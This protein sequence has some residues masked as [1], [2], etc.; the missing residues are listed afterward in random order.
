M[1]STITP[2]A[3]PGSTRIQGSTWNVNAS[4]LFGVS[5][6]VSGVVSGAE[7]EWCRTT[8]TMEY[9]YV[10]V[11][12][13]TSPAA[14]DVYGLT[15]LS[16]VDNVNRTE[17][18]NVATLHTK[19]EKIYLDVGTSGFTQLQILGLNPV[20][21]DLYG[22]TYGVVSGFV[23][24]PQGSVITVQPYIKQEKWYDTI[25]SEFDIT[26]TGSDYGLYLSGGA[27]PNEEQGWKN[28]TN[29]GDPYTWYIPHWRSGWRYLETQGVYTK[30]AVTHG[31]AEEYSMNGAYLTT[32]ED[33]WE[34]DA[35]GL[36][37]LIN[38]IE[39]IVYR[40]K[41]SIYHHRMAIPRP[42][43]SDEDQ[44]IVEADRV[45]QNTVY[46]TSRHAY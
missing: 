37:R 34:D 9:S 22:A 33:A 44:F 15:Q 19:R 1:P 25:H 7:E 13:Y 35:A 12:D 30:K 10:R 21:S 43:Y 28:G 41:S 11:P 4:A 23:M 5:G 29:L 17:M 36:V 46:D 14:L 8:Q 18:Y 20:S 26:Q 24:G 39:G 2:V 45:A 31:G 40:F 27:G 6:I 16:A 42:L 3:R 32:A 38:C